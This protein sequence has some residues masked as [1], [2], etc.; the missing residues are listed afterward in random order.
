MTRPEWLRC[1]HGLSALPG[2]NQED[3]GRYRSCPG[4]SGSIRCRPAMSLRIDIHH[5]SGGTDGRISQRA[6]PGDEFHAGPSSGARLRESLRRLQSVQMQEDV[7]R[8]NQR[9][10]P[11]RRVSGSR[12][13]KKVWI[14]PESQPV[15]ALQ[16]AQKRIGGTVMTARCARE[17]WSGPRESNPF[18]LGVN[19]A[20]HQMD[21]SSLSWMGTSPSRA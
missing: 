5:P 8:T 7:K 3:D 11:V 21:Q 13:G 15:E 20:S 10:T 14:D 17:S 9:R 18:L 19:Q 4:F 16:S 2:H 12:G 1:S 6:F